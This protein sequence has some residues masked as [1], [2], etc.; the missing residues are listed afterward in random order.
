MSFDR[1]GKASRTSNYRP[2]RGMSNSAV[3]A[4]RK[5][6]NARY[7]YKPATDGAHGGL[8]ESALITAQKKVGVTADGDYGRNARSA[9]AWANYSLETGSRINCT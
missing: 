8:T 1:A 6:L 2:D 5:N 7:G 4:V 9:T 3:T